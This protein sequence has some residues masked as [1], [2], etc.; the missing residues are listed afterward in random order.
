LVCRRFDEVV[1][2]D[3]FHAMRAAG[4]GAGCFRQ[5]APTPAP[6]TPTVDWRLGADAMFTLAP[7]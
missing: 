7:R 5:P 3:G 6:P 2:Y 4:L 1:R